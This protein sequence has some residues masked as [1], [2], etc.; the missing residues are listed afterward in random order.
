MPFVP[1]DLSGLESWFDADAITGL[2]ADDPVSQWDD[3]SGN[4]H[5]A[6]Q[7]TSANR[8]L[9]RT[10]ALNG[11]PGVEFD[12][13]NDYLAS[14][15]TYPSEQAR[16]VFIVSQLHA[17]P[18]G[19]NQ[20]G[21]AFF[22]SS[23]SRATL[24]L[25]STTG[26]LSG[27]RITHW[28]SSNSWQ[29]GGDADADPHVHTFQYTGSSD[30]V[31]RRNGVEEGDNAIGS[32]I[33]A[34]DR[35]ILGDGQL[36]SSARL[37]GHLF[38]VVVYDRR[39]TAGEI[40]QVEEYLLLKWFGEW[41]HELEG[42]WDPDDEEVDLSW[43]PPDDAT[44]QHVIRMESSGGA[45]TDLG[46]AGAAATSFSDGT[47]V[48]GTRYFYLIR[49]TVDG[50][51]Y[52]SDEII[53]RAEWYEDFE[54]HDTGAGEHDGFDELWNTTPVYSVVSDAGYVG[55]AYVGHNQDGVGD[56]PHML[57]FD[58]PGVVSDAHRIVAI[59]QSDA[60]GSTSTR[61]GAGVAFAA[62]DDETTGY[63]VAIRSGQIGLW[64]L[65]DGVFTGIDT[66]SSAVSRNVRGVVDV[67]W[68]PAT[69]E[70][71]VYTYAVGGSRSA[72]PEISHTD[73]SPLAA[74]YLGFYH[75]MRLYSQRF[76]SIEVTL[77]TSAAPPAKPSISAEALDADTARL[78][79]TPSDGDDYELYQDEVLIEEWTAAEIP[80]TH[81]IDGLTP[82]EEYEWVLTATNEEGSTDSDPAEL[83]MP[84]A[85]DAPTPRVDNIGTTSADLSSEN[86]D[87]EAINVRY[88][89]VTSGGAAVDDTTIPVDGDTPHPLTGLTADAGYVT[90]MKAEYA[91]GWSDWGDEVTWQ[92]FADTIPDAY[93]TI[94]LTP[95]WGGAV[96]GATA[97]LTWELEDGRT[98]EALEISEDLGETWTAIGGVGSTDESAEFDSTAFDDGFTLARLELDDGAFIYH[99][100]FVIENAI[101]V[102]RESGWDEE[103]TFARYLLPGEP[104][105]LG[106]DPTCAPNEVG[107]TGQEAATSV[108]ASFGPVD[109]VALTFH[110]EAWVAATMRTWGIA[111]GGVFGT[112][113]RSA[114]GTM[115]GVALTANIDGDADDPNNMISIRAGVEHFQLSNALQDS[116]A[117]I[118]VG[119]GIFRVSVGRGGA[120]DWLSGGGDQS[121]SVEVP[122]AMS[123]WWNSGKECNPR[124]IRIFLRVSR[125]DAE[126]FPARYRIRAWCGTPHPHSSTGQKIGFGLIDE[127]VDLAAELDCGHASFITQKTASHYGQYSWRTLTGFVAWADE[128]DCGEP[129]EPEA[130]GFDEEET[131]AADEDCLLW[132]G[133]YESDRTTLAWEV[134]TSSDYFG[135]GGALPYLVEPD[136]YGEQ[137]VDFAEGTASITQVG[138]AVIDKAQTAGDQDS[139]WIT[140]RLS[141]VHGRRCR[142]L[143]FV[144]GVGWVVIADGPASSPR[145][146]ADYSSGSFNI[147]DTRET[148]RK[149]RAF[150]SGGT[151]WV[152]P[153]GVEGGYGEH[154][155]GAGTVFLVDPAEP[156]EGTFDGT[157]DRVDVGVTS[158]KKKGVR[159]PWDPQGE[160]L[161]SGVQWTWP[162]IDILW[163]AQGTADPWNVIS[164]NIFLGFGESPPSVRSGD[165][166][167]FITDDA[168]ELPADSASID[169]A[170]RYAGPTSEEFPYHLE[171]LT[172]GE[173]LKNLYDGVYS[174]LDPDTGEL[175]PTGIR[176]DEDAL[177]EMTDPVR[178]RITEPVEDVRKW[179]EEH[180]YAP[181][182]YAP[183]LDF[184][185]RIS[186]VSQ[187]APA[188]SED[189]TDT[190]TDAVT[191]PS[192]DWSA[193]ERIV[194]VIEFTY[195]RHY[196]PADPP[197][198]PAADGIVAFDVERN[199]ENLQSIERHDER[200]I[201]L[202]G[203][204]FAAVGDEEG[205]ELGGTVE[206]GHRIAAARHH[207]LMDR[208]REGAPTIR[209]AVMRSHCAEWRVG[210]FVKNT[211]SWI[212][213][214]ATGR[215][216]ADWI[217][218]VVAIADLDCAWRLPTIERVDPKGAP[219]IPEPDTEPSVYIAIAQ[220]GSEG[221]V[222]G[223]TLTYAAS[224]YSEDHDWRMLA[225]LRHTH[226]T[227]GVVT[228]IEDDTDITLDLDPIPGVV[229][230]VAAESTWETGLAHG[231][232][233]HTVNAAIRVQILDYSGEVV[234]EKTAETAW[235]TDDEAPE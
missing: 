157:N 186:P 58:D 162:D 38:E 192:P 202:S 153:A 36:G 19:G 111:G 205:N 148:E 32:N 26:A 124:N 182:G 56:T 73:P 190:L 7:G 214:F 191:E 151:T 114:E 35:I 180:A 37:K 172:V 67:E 219:P 220:P 65:D 152:F 88:R 137:E 60:A 15:A 177:L 176:Y 159:S 47:A 210:T 189:V 201:Q 208:Y 163:R 144:D 89:T 226:G 113:T 122:I 6:T 121:W 81:D 77:G 46:D 173:F 2:S 231:G 140:E 198:D 211:L 78:T 130:E 215:R 197:D 68:D 64:R 105:V 115:V 216:G 86:I 117:K 136:R 168:G 181:T 145:L 83:T 218:Q 170:V 147:R 44:A 110:E 200:K 222:G 154:D 25:R 92:T 95:A 227:T 17:T 196:V 166:V 93:A 72:T 128:G 206:N 135:F 85:G 9:Y 146:E 63:I 209:A 1:S 183:A 10:S 118:G 207:Y 109:P 62:R 203:L 42:T 5:H 27:N 3:E 138:V 28:D 18:T 179:A 171:G 213:D 13:S 199:F 99:D 96:S 225:T 235:F 161:E 34:H 66:D 100:G 79:L 98:V 97:E 187:A 143:R 24:T 116:P 184:D 22:G 12:G 228:V 57:R 23:G 221:G 49:A 193:G 165:F 16:T 21:V 224:H 155:L 71:A 234:D 119:T 129:P 101:D 40:E 174:P 14:A 150:V 39:L 52:D 61:N 75:G 107:H 123:W 133:V 31:I 53:V 164:P 131:P 87:P 102:T 120:G 132:L 217:G 127:T 195:E 29:P 233:D 194:N 160:I 84:G 108:K 167:Y 94:F 175:V 229:S 158:A 41:V 76:D 185:G 50:T 59:V 80:A 54:F 223:L 106:P 82:T 142:L 204:L 69:G 230:N 8:P 156:F 126:N 4:D 149:H 11:L 112:G 20:T 104:L 91:E 70:I 232:M 141:T 55:S 33:P 178:A 134:T 90:D 74:G 125:P 51:D 43:N 212:P 188:T 103:D 45:E 139:G 30:V 48:E 169:L